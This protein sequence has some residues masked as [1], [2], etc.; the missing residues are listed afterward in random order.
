MQVVKGWLEGEGTRET[1]YDVAW[2]GKRQPDE[3]GRVPAVPDTVDPKTGSYSNEFGAATLTVVWKDPDFDPLAPAFYYVRVLEVPTPRHSLLDAL[4]LGVDPE[5]TGQPH[6]IQ[7]R[8][9][10][11]PIFY[12]PA[13]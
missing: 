8:A 9:Y 11:S 13:R 4:A 3:R 12:R 1:V 5:T 10:T 7:E 2:S 6:S